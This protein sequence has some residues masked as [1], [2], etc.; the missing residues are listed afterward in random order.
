VVTAHWNAF[1]YKPSPGLAFDLA[2]FN[3]PV[4]YDKLF[5]ISPTQRGAGARD[6][7][8]AEKDAQTPHL[9]KQ[10]QAGNVALPAD[11]PN[12]LQLADRYP[13]VSVGI[14]PIKEA[15][16]V[17]D[18]FRL[19]GELGGSGTLP[20]REQGQSLEDYA[21]MLKASGLS[22][23]ERTIATKA[24]MQTVYTDQGKKILTL[25]SAITK[26]KDAQRELNT[27]MGTEL[28]VTGVF[29]QDWLQAVSNWMGSES[30][31]QK[32]VQKQASDAGFATPQ[33]FVNAWKNKTKAVHA[34]G[35][36]QHF[37]N[38]MP[39]QLFHHGTDPLNVLRSTGEYLTSGG[40]ALE[41]WHPEAYLNANLHFLTRSTGLALRTVGGTVEQ[42]KADAQATTAFLNAVVGPGAVPFAQGLSYDEAKGKMRKALNEN[43]SWL[44]ILF[45]NHDSK[46]ID[47]PTGK[48]LN[49]AGDLILL[50][51]PGY[52]G[53]QVA[54]GSVELA[55]KS[56]YLNYSASWAFNDLA[57]GNIGRAAARLEGGPG[58][59]KLVTRAAPLIKSG[60]MNQEQFR[61]H[62]SDLYAHG[63]TTI[64]RTGGKTIKIE[65]PVLT[66]L[67]AKTLPTPGAPGIKWLEAKN[68][69]RQAADQI[70]AELL[71]SPVAGKAGKFIS[72]LRAS[73]AHNVSAGSR[74]IF[75][76]KMPERLHDYVLRETGDAKLANQFEDRFVAARAK[77]NLVGIKKI[78]DDLLEQHNL[79][80]PLQDEAPTPEPYAPVLGTEGP[81]VFKFPSGGEREAD[82]ALQAIGGWT[83]KINSFLTRVAQGHS[84][85]ILGGPG[86]FSL[87]YKHMFADTLR[88]AVAEEG[89]IG[90]YTSEMK[91][92]R[93]EIEKLTANDPRYS[94]QLGG[95]L[96]RTRESETRYLL[97]RGFKADRT[98]FQTG[99][100]FGKTN[101]M[102]AAGGF[103][104]RT[105]DDDGLK[106]YQEASSGGGLSPF[107]Q[108]VLHNKTYRGMWKSARKA[109]P[110][111]AEEYAQVIFQ[112]FR[113]VESGLLSQGHTFDDALSV[114][115]TN[116]GAD[117]DKKLGQYIA[118]N[119]LDFKVTAGQVDRLW[120]PDRLTGAWIEKLMTFNKWNRS[121]LATRMLHKTYAE[122][123]K[124]G[125]A[126]GPAF[127]VSADLAERMVVHHMLDFAN[128][129]Q[130]EQNLRWV[131]YFAT[132][133]RL[134]WKWV[135]GTMVRHPGYSAA[136]LD[137]Q[138]AMGGD[139]NID[140]TLG[141]HKLAI[142]AARLMWIPGKEYSEMSPLVLGFAGALSG[143]Y[144]GAVQAA[145]GN[146]GNLLSRNDTVV[147]YAAKMARIRAGN[148]PATY[149]YLTAGLDERSKAFM[150]ARINSYQND[151]FNEH[152]HFAPESEAV[153]HVLWGAMANEAWRSNL[154]LPVVPTHGENTG[155]KLLRQFMALNDPKKRRKFLDDHS[156]LSLYFGIYQDPNDYLHVRPLWA[157]YT[158]A[159]DKRDAERSLIYE[160]AKTG[161][162]TP[163]LRLARKRSDQ[164]F[165]KVFDALIKEDLNG[166]DPAKR[167][168]VNGQNYGLWGQ[169]VAV[170]PLVDP[171][172][173]LVGTKEHPGLFPNLEQT[174]GIPGATVQ[175]LRLELK[176]LSDPSYVAKTFQDP[177]EAKFRRGEILQQLEVFKSYP[178]D[179]LG[180]LELT[181]NRDYVGKYWDSYN[182]KYD[183]IAAMP[184]NEKDVAYAELRAWKD[185]QD[186]PVVINGVKFPSPLRMAWATM[187][188]VTRK[189]R[190]AGIAGGGWDHLADYEKQLLGVKVPVG[191]S[192]N[193]SGWTQLMAQY[194][195]DAGVN[196]TRLPKGWGATVAK[197]VEKNGGDGFYKDY[198][199]AQKPTFVRL[200]QLAPIIESKHHSDWVGLL[201][202]AKAH[203][204]DTTPYWRDYVNNWIKPQLAKPENK[205][206]SREVNLFG[207]DF[208]YSLI[209]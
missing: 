32:V 34:S 145:K 163:E 50:R 7:V 104:R 19:A 157:R 153:K 197:Y 98:T 88:R 59:E 156:E 196:R 177:N 33:D 105:I 160:Q 62:L 161:G 131:S 191:T 138:S 78:E 44:R 86:G 74:G 208:L 107:V 172:K 185:S 89:F 141:G 43:P 112:R 18:F 73:F 204:Q 31:F 150:N 110:L 116:R 20:V 125:M 5:G 48:A 82:N 194:R 202:D 174:S 67:R 29:N 60:Q 166:T 133:H 35:W 36:S 49:L 109:E 115:R 57:K 30:Y 1:Q 8:Q 72:S 21:R 80:F 70:D 94:R 186:R 173:V 187:D 45:P 65:G 63:E 100:H 37:L 101:Y 164:Q 144:V 16:S 92:A 40:A 195:H 132:K 99:E 69:L 176:L 143:G 139:G 52:T 199:F 205:A 61:A 203:R 13:T 206:F 95:F 93:S 198:L 66:S 129:L 180:S 126:P 47:S 97:G 193:W 127:E 26:L 6:A 162:Y 11:Q 22:Q 168:E 192:Q 23:V 118:D 130:V 85:I 140:F 111:S 9:L 113:D 158:Q 189:E 4:D 3:G 12:T 152:G 91:V 171:R 147:H 184:K 142:P 58:A 128:R 28:P 190:L 121:Q 183:Q 41:P 181:Y 38:A 149:G 114:L 79:K 155:Q 54:A 119:N 134:Y 84:R 14:L 188:P 10:I 120:G 151:Y 39:L 148:M 90:G 24:G 27:Q 75:D 182:K 25:S 96:A 87:F 15:G 207:P 81:S 64:T 103:L 56:E 201:G 83:G 169:Q 159:L 76:P 179:A 123:T 55:S 17:E 200:A 77:D 51:K 71:A 124:A 170:D 42:T 154:P 137:A 117:A 68:G 175:H 136:V 46:W 122:M 53:E 102:T 108:L 2:R 165:G 135:L 178:K 209:R 146:F 167:K 106:A